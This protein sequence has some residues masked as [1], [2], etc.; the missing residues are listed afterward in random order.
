MSGEVV[1][2]T[3]GARRLGKKTAEAFAGAGAD[4]LIHF[5]SSKEEA[6]Q[7]VVELQAYGVH[8]AAYQADLSAEDGPDLLV[9]RVF[10]DG[11][12]PRI[13]INS[14][15]SYSTNTFSSVTSKS[16]EHDAALI[17]YAPLA[18]SRRFAE[19][20]E[21]GSILNV[22]DARMVDYDSQHLSYHL[23]KRTLMSLTSILALELAPSFRVNGI[24]PGIILPPEHGTEQQVERSRLANPLRAIGSAE[25]FTRTLL[26]LSSSPFITGEVIFVDGGRHLHGR[27][28]G[29]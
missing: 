9:E 29:G 2:V 7:T 28:Y 21:S 26:F 16:L 23:A 27:I 5:H 19:K 1:L 22:L 10:E 8:A 17:A 20:A 6:E 12:S 24:A 13:L 15:S 25:D 11:F 3:G 4:V 14:A 18:L